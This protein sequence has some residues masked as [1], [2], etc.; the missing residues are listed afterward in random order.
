MRSVTIATDG[1]VICAANNKGTV[2]VWKLLRGEHLSPHVPMEKFE[3]HSTYILRCLL[4]PD[5]RLLATTSADHTVKLWNVDDLTLEKTLVGHKMWVWDCVF[6]AD[7]AYLLTASSDNSSKLW[8]ISQGE[9]IKHYTGH[10]KAVVCV[11][12]NDNAPE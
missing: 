12:L 11:A 3:A 9:A 6:S 8:D 2:M 1:S 10:H 5:V 4:S 7:C